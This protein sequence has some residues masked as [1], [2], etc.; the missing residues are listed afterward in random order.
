M[1]ARSATEAIRRAGE[2]PPHF[3]SLMLKTPQG[4]GGS[5][6]A[7]ASSG[8]SRLSSAHQ[9]RAARARPARASVRV[10]RAAIGC[11]TSSSASGRRVAQKPL[12]LRQGVA[13][14]G[15]GAQGDVRARRA[16]AARAGARDPLP[17]ARPILTL[18]TRKPRPRY[19]SASRRV[20]SVGLDA[21]GDR[22]GQRARGRGR[23][24]RTAAARAPAP[25]RSCSAMST[26]ARAAGRGRHLAAE[27]PGQRGQ[28]AHVLP[29]QPVERAGASAAWQAWLVS[30]VTCGSG[31]AAPRPTSPVLVAERPRSRSRWR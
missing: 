3:I 25:S 8:V 9:Q 16:R 6:S 13:L 22:G 10:W 31:E 26:A 17:A 4:A 12:G 14:V 27:P 24:D 18:R 29:D 20:S 19:S 23:A 5:A 30:P 2:T 11:S 21:D 7:K 28:A 15:V 1:P